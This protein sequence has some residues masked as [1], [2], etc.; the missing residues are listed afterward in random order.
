M[1][2]FARLLVVL[3]LAA[4]AAAGWLYVRATRPFRGYA[5]AEQFVEIPAGSGSRAIGERLVAAG[6]VR[7]PI[8]FRLGLWMSGKSRRLEAGEYRFDHAMTSLE[9]I[10]K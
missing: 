10:D 5:G 8:T 6:V 7:D 3:V 4:A 9:V 2:A 1:K